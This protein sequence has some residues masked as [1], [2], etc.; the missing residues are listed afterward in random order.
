MVCN[1]KKAVGENL[2]VPRPRLSPKKGA[3]KSIDPA[4]VVTT[5]TASRFLRCRATRLARVL[6]C[7]IEQRIGE[8]P[9]PRDCFQGQLAMAGKIVVKPFLVRGFAELVRKSG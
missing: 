9:R 1:R 3:L 2:P 8:P 6:C 4:A 7:R 5:R